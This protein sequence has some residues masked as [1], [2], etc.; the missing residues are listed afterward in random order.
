MQCLS[1]CA[2]CLQEFPD[3]VVGDFSRTDISRF[4]A[5]AWRVAWKWLEKFQAMRV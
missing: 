4:L 2:G 1:F 5:R 3:D